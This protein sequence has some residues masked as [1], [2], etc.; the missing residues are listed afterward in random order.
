MGGLSLRIW[1]FLLGFLSERDSGKQFL[2]LPKTRLEKQE[3]I[4][5]WPIFVLSLACL[6]YGMEP[7]S[8]TEAVRKAPTHK[9]SILGSYHLRASRL[10]TV[11]LG[12]PVAFWK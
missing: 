11:G 9:I 10:A 8:P 5:T 3:I 4:P 1:P 7:K 6:A 12:T 2:D